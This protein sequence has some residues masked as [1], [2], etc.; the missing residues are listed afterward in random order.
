MVRHHLH[1]RALGSMPL[2]AMLAC[3]AVN[4]A[5]AQERFAS[6]QQ[7]VT[8]LVAAMRT[9]DNGALAKIL[10]SG[11][12]RLLH[13][14]D[15]AQDATNAQAFVAAYDAQHTVTQ[16]SP[17]RAVLLI[18]TD[19]WPLPLELAKATGGMWSFDTRGAGGEILARRMGSNELATIAVLHAVVQAQRDFVR[20]D[21]DHDGLHTY[22]SAL[23][24]SAGLRDGL[25]W[26]TIGGELP[27]PLATAIAPTDAEALVATS[28]SGLDASR[29]SDP[30][31][32]GPYH[33]YFYR[34]LARQGRK[35]T[36]GAYRYTVGGE[37]VGG[38]ALIA[39]PARHG[40]SGLMSFIVNQDGVVFEKNLGKASATVAAKVSSFN[41]DKTWRLAADLH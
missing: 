26:A 9:Q 38:F 1:Q 28:G 19:E 31:A 23:S 6:P 29:R 11:G 34:F 41:P 35:A 16:K 7:G 5:V 2:I 14:G 3:L 24:S 33:G 25:F 39:Y 18:G 4:P 20:R 17:E 22:A 10:G 15:A 8:R 36:G 30:A 32:F 40:N 13:S 21:P 27:S 37:Q 12:Q